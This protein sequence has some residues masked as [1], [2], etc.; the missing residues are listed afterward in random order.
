MYYVEVNEKIVM[1]S[2]SLEEAQKFVEQKLVEQKIKGTV[3]IYDH[4]GRLVCFYK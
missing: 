4:K 1:E 2:S 3:E